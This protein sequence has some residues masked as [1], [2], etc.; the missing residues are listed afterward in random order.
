MMNALKSSAAAASKKIKVTFKTVTDPVRRR[1]GTSVVAGVIAGVVGAI[2]KFGWEVPFPPR[3]PERNETNP[4]Q[5]FLEMFGFSPE[6]THQTYSFLGNDLPWVSF[7]VHFTFSIV[8]GVLYS[9]IAE[10]WPKVKLWQGVAL[11]IVLDIFFHI[12]LMPLMGIVPAPWD[13]PFGELFSEFF[14]HMVWMWSIE[15]VRRD[16]R[17]RITGEPDAEYPLTAR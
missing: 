6:F 16:M 14:G 4:P 2:V 9:V 11:G 13:Q 5:A 15:V 10:Y 17:S 3:S 1:I 8:F 12:I 7:I